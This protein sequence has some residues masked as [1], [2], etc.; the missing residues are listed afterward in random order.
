MWRGLMTRAQ[1]SCKYNCKDHEV[2]GV[3]RSIYES[4]P[5][6]VLRVIA[7]RVSAQFAVAQM[8]HQVR[9]VCLPLRKGSD[10]FIRR[11]AIFIRSQSPFNRICRVHISRLYCAKTNNPRTTEQQAA[12]KVRIPAKANGVSEGSRT[13]LLAQAEH[14]RS[15]A[16]LAF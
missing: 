6:Q 12:G 11:A 2:R 15:V 5:S 8:C 13:A 10:R 16:T 3:G 1:N 9:I 14:H 4:I 7:I